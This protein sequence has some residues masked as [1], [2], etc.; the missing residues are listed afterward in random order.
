LKKLTLFLL[1]PF[2]VFG[3]YS[4]QEALSTIS[5]EEIY[6]NLQYLASDSLKGRAAGTDEN[7][8]AAM[9]IADKF[10]KYGLQPLIKKETFGIQKP[11]VDEDAKVFE[12]DVEDAPWFNEYFQRFSFEKTTL[13]ENN[14]LTV[15]RE[16][17]N[18]Y[19]QKSYSFGID[20]II[21]YYGSANL[22]AEAPVV[23]A[24][25][26]IDKGENGYN[27]YLDSTGTEIDVRYKIVILMDGYPQQ[28]DTG[29]IF[30]K[31]RNPL[32]RN[33]L[34]KADAALEKGALAVVLVSSPLMNDPQIH[35]K[36]DRL[37]KAFLR[38]SDH[39]LELPKRSLPIIYAD[40]NVVQDI[41]EKPV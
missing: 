26:G 15:I 25:Y 27:D 1:F 9:Y 3:Q 38:S 4:K 34:R 2:L 29:S 19:L 33:P 18:G 40:K 13:T 8:L 30:S 20:F 21:Q 22:D 12:Y 10:K 23:L 17:E 39:L 6:G 24:G 37:S 41:L 35:V 14:S 11:D 31:A 5:V 7:L 32:Y 28:S 16:S 36:Y